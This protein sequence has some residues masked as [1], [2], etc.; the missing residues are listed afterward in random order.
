MNDFNINER[1]EKSY[2]AIV[3]AFVN[4]GHLSTHEFF[5]KVF[6]SA[7]ELIPY[8]E[9]GSFYEKDEDMF[10][11]IFSKGYDMNVLKKLAFNEENLF[12]GFEVNREGNIDVYEFHNK[13]RDESKFSLEEIE[14]FKSLGTY[15]EFTSL[16]APIQVDGMNIGLLCFE[17]FDGETYDGSSKLILKLY[18]QLISNFYT[19]MVHAKRE[20]ERY[21][22]IIN[23]MVSAIELKDKYT[24]GHAKRVTNLAK[25]LAT[26]MGLSESQITTVEAAAILHDVGKIGISSEVLNKPGKLTLEEYEIIK[27]HPSFTKKILENIKEFSEVVKIAYMH[28]EYH[29]GKGYP[30]G[31]EGH[32]IPIESAIIS[33]VDAFDAMTTDRSYRSAMSEEQ[34]IKILIEERGE[35]FNPQVVDAFIE[36]K[37]LNNRFVT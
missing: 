27:E 8:A 22:E 4:S 32:G 24:E 14:I 36:W 34:S 9:K 33:V 3:D 25:G 10:R 13:Q 15:A 18:A 12:I 37:K 11:P 31:I 26:H 6:E 19:Q 17:R 2:Q 30:Q 7:F 5:S 16:Y 23:A 20:R 21:Q 28:H 1:L 29:N 35:Q